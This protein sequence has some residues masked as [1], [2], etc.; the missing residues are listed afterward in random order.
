ML[1]HQQ[2]E[3][4]KHFLEA[5][6]Q[7]THPTGLGSLEKIYDLGLI[8]FEK[9]CKATIDDIVSVFPE[10]KVEVL[11]Y[12]N[13]KYEASFIEKM[14]DL[15]KNKKWILVDLKV[16]PG[17]DLIN[18]LRHLSDENV[19]QLFNFKGKEVYNLKLPIESRIVV[20]VQRDFLEKEISYPYFLNIFGPILSL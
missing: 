12:E 5:V 1:T 8:I 7:V 3:K 15:L 14:V 11:K 16:D 4:M 19:M 9:D 13:N 2:E 10:N 17:H 18:Q 20:V 6:N